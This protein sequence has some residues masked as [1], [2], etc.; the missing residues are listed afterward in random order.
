MHDKNIRNM[1]FNC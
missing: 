1:K